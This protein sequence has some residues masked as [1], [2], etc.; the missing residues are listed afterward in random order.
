MFLV[1]VKKKKKNLLKLI[2]ACIA[3]LNTR[4]LESVGIL[5]QEK[6]NIEFQDGSHLGFPIGTVLAIFYR[7]VTILTMKYQVT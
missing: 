7:Q 5:V 3:N 2:I 1:Q 6:F 4:R